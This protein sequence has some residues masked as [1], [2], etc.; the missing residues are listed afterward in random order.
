MKVC[1]KCG[2]TYDAWDGGCDCEDEDCTSGE[3]QVLQD[4]EKELRAELIKMASGEK[5]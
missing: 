1:E 5:S 2:A 3:V 4:K